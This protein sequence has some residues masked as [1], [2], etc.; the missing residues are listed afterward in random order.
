MMFDPENFL[1]H[2]ILSKIQAGISFTDK[3]TNTLCKYLCVCIKSQGQING[4]AI[5]N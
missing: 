3:N 5:L 4:G 1:S 2:P